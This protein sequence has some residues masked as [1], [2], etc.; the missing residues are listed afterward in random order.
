MSQSHR[1]NNEGLINR[2]KAIVFKFNNLALL[3]AFIIFLEVPEV[4]S[5]IN[6]SPFVFNSRTSNYELYNIKKYQNKANQKIC[7]KKNIYTNSKADD[8]GISSSSNC[9]NI[10]LLSNYSTKDIGKFIISDL[11]L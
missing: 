4:V 3:K 10:G 7:I 11:V 1:L 6:T 2:D 8:F 9:F 5:P